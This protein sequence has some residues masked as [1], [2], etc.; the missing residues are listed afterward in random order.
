MYAFLGGE[1]RSSQEL[2]QGAE[3]NL[4]KYARVADN[5]LTKKKEEIQGLHTQTGKALSLVIDD[6]GKTLLEMRNLQGVAKEI[7]QTEKELDEQIKKVSAA[8]EEIL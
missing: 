4:T 7:E 3:E 2:A 6:L 8:A 1:M 5:E